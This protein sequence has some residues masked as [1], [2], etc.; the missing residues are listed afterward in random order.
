[1]QSRVGHALVLMAVIRPMLTG[2]VV[3]TSLMTILQTRVSSIRSWSVGRLLEKPAA[4]MLQ[5]VRHGGGLFHIYV[6]F[7]VLP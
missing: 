2:I 4:L 1:M 3:R 6:P 7:M 5:R